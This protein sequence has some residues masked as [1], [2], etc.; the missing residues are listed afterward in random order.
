MLRLGPDLSQMSEISLD[1]I[2]IQNLQSVQILGPV[3]RF[4]SSWKRAAAL[5]GQTPSHYT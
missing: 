3:Y 1:S 2:K 4:E 5:S